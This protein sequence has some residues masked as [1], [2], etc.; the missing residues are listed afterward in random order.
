MKLDVWELVGILVAG[1]AA[2]CLAVAILEVA[3]KVGKSPLFSSQP[4]AS[5]NQE[6]G[7]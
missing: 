2:V 6:R 1:L 3:E 4:Q 7:Q 5:Q